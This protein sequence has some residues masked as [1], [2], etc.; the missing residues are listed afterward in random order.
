[1]TDVRTP[2]RMLRYKQAIQSP[3]ADCF[4]YCCRYLAL[5]EFRIDD[6]DGLDWAV[7]LVN[8]DRIRLSVSSTGRWMPYYREVCRHLDRERSLCKVHGTADQPNACVQY[9]PFSCHYRVLFSEDVDVDQLWVDHGRMQALLEGTEVD[10]RRRRVVIPPFE[11]LARTFETLP[12]ETVPGPEVAP[13]GNGAG[14]AGM[15]IATARAVRTAGPGE[16]GGGFEGEGPLRFG[17]PALAS[18]CDSCHAYCCTRVE[19]P[20][21][22]PSNTRLVDYL[23]YA[24]GFPG[25]EVVLNGEE[26][27]LSIESTCRNLVGSRCGIYGRDERPVRCQFYDAWSCTFRHTYGSGRGGGLRLGFDDLPALMSCFSFDP[28]GDVLAVPEAGEIASEVSSARHGR[29]RD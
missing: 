22:P 7:F 3:C 27:A 24:L 17:T 14:S 29:P 18:P 10:E 19:F 9:N 4:A 2:L 23:R 28:T 20:L 25:V 8:F 12:L 5:P 21:D 15:T 6:F 1:L 11:E 16:A 26:W 13:A